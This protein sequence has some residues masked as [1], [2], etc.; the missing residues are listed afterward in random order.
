VYID[1]PPLISLKDVAGSFGLNFF[2]DSEESLFIKQQIPPRYV[3]A[4]KALSMIGR[5]S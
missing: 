3:D 1:K 5:G 4:H 2:T